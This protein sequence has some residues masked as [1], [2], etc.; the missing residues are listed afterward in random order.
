MSRAATAV[1]GRLGFAKTVVVS[2]YWPQQVGHGVFFSRRRS[3]L[4]NARATRA[5]FWG[6]GGGQT[7]M[8]WHSLLTSQYSRQP[9]GIKVQSCPVLR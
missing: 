9:L 3:P 6:G 4:T 1:W 7:K 8:S 2:G 5:S